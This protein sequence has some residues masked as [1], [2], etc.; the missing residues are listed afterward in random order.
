MVLK[1]C[2][3]AAF[4]LFSLLGAASAFAAAAPD[5][6]L[7]L[8]PVSPAYSPG[9]TSFTVPIVPG[10]NG[11]TQI[12][13]A[14]NVGGG[15][16]NLQASSSAPWLV[17]TVGAQTFC[18]LRGACIPVQ[19]ALQTSSLA[20]GTYNGTVTIADPNA[21]DA[22]QFVTVTAQVGGDVPSSLEFFLPPGGTVSQVF[23]TVSKVKSTIQPASPWLSFVTGGQGSGNVAYKVTVTA[24]NTTGTS[25]ATIT[26]SG[27][28]FAP[29][30]KPISVALDVTTDPILAASS[31]T[32][33]FTGV[34]GGMK[35]SVTLAVSN[36]G[37][38]TL[39]VSGVTATPATGTWLS[40]QSV[41]NGAGVTI[42]ADPTSLTPGTYPGTVTIASNAANSSVVIPVNFTLEA[43]SAPVAFAGLAVNNGTFA[44]GE[45]LAQG[46]ISAVFGDQFTLGALAYPSGLPLPTTINGTQVFVNNTAAPLFFISDRQI[47]FQV[48]FEIPAGN[49]TVQIVRNGQQGNKISVT[50]AARTPRFLLVNGGPYPLLLNSA[51]PPAETGISG[52]PANAG[53][54]VVAYVIGLGQT[55]PVLQTGAAA[56]SGNNLALVDNVQV[57]FGQQTP[58]SKSTCIAPQF[59]G[60]APGFVG[61]YQINFAVPKGLPS[62]NNSFYFLVDGVGSDLSQILI[63]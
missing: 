24:G 18:S 41:N 45:P 50:I 59:A 26:L 37:E 23:T 32:V 17:P 60:A 3:I 16:L 15:S 43:E 57:C 39:S 34:Q 4:G 38:G 28:S 10:S 44:Q 46:D 11:P 40:A 31:N 47:D 14:F 1:N 54:V 13:D 7:T 48:P 56:P 52:H 53:D 62:G 25:N 8:T 61:L 2:T 21:V 9:G 27:S 20:A 6:S 55:N 12:V 33:S 42:T 51:T 58:F 30:N 36:S 22:P 29:D 49:A 35:Q 63:Q 5:L 19:I